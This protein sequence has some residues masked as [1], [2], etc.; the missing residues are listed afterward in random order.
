VRLLGETLE[1]I[2]TKLLNYSGCYANDEKV[3]N[4]IPTKKA[5]LKS[6]ADRVFIIGR[7]PLKSK[8]LS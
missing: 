1:T 3:F 7:F 5:V 8:T 6:R 4:K 2:T